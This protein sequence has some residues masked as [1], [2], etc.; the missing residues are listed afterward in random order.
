MNENTKALKLFYILTAVLAFLLA[1]IR[2]AMTV[3]YLDANYGLYPSGNLLPTLSHLLTLAVLLAAAAFG[4]ALSK[5]YAWPVSP[6][7]GSTTAFFSCLTAFMIAAVTLLSLYNIFA[8]GAEADKFSII[9]IIVSIPTA[10]F[11]LALIKPERKS[12]PALAIMS[13]FPIAWFADNLLESYFDTSLLITSPA[14]TFRELS[15]LAVMLYLL[16]ES[17]F[18]IDRSSGKLFFIMSSIAPIIMITSS[19]PALVLPKMLLIG[20]SDSF[21]CY[22]VEF[23]SALFILSRGFAFA[24]S[25]KALPRPPKEENNKD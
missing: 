18:L 21:L 15:L 10:I 20:D 13:F 19:L 6:K 24:A 12:T 22:A 8:A 25:P 7:V 9:R 5:K 14:K 2:I 1:G 11:F 4:L 17:R 3:L 23:A 16:C